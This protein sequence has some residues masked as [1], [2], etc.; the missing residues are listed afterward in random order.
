M[1][2]DPGDF[3]RRRYELQTHDADFYAYLVDLVLAERLRSLHYAF[4]HLGTQAA[5]RLWATAEH[6]Q[7]RA[8]RRIARR[9]T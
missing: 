3:E 7:G 4:S 6:H 2:T 5:Q 1:P 8:D 9:A